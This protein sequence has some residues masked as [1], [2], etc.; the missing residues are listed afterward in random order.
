MS[1]K[2]VSN[3]FL[4]SCALDIPSVWY[5]TCWFAANFPLAL[6]L[7]LLPNY[8]PRGK[9]PEEESMDSFVL[10]ELLNTCTWLLPWP[11]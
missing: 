9:F 1:S 7:L 8:I 10:Y 2:T 11:S 4:T 5:T 6:K 3:C